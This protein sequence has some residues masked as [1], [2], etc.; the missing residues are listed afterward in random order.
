MTEGVC[1]HGAPRPREVTGV[2]LT[3]SWLLRKGQEFLQEKSGLVGGAAQWGM[4]WGFSPA[5]M[6]V[7]GA[8]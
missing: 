4:G 8:S 6:G 3:R 5:S 2:K 1:P 7:S